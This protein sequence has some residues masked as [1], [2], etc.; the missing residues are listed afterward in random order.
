MAA[1][2]VLGVSGTKGK[3]TTAALAA[4]LAR[5]AGVRVALA[6]NIGAPVLDLLDGEKAQLTVAG[7]LQLPDRGPRAAVRRSH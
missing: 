6:G 7:A 4:H 5:A 2:G 1:A 3:S